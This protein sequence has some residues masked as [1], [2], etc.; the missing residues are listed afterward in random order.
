VRAGGKPEDTRLQVFGDEFGAPDGTCICDTDLCAAH[1]L[2]LNRLMDG[3]VSGFSAFNI[4]R[5]S[6]DAIVLAV[7][8]PEFLQWGAEGIHAL[9]KPV[10]V[11]YDVKSL[12]PKDA[13]DGRL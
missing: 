6:Y 5:G 1:L 7:A 11:L 2:A 9:G 13:S 3:K 4:G 10:H 12:L 8:H